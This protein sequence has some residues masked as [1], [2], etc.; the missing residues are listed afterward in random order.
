MID[1]NHQH[2]KRDA[3]SNVL[4]ARLDSV[5][6]HA[7][8]LEQL[9]R[10]LQDIAL[11]ALE[12]ASNDRPGRSVS[13]S[14]VG[15]KCARSVQLSIWPSFHPNA[16]AIKQAPLTDE[17][18]RI[19]ARGHLTEPLV[20]GW[21]KSLFALWTHNSRGYQFGFATADGQIKGYADGVFQT[22]VDDAG[23][24]PLWE[25]KTLGG[26]SFYMARRHGI[27]KAHPKYYD[28]V[29][30]LMAYLNYP[31]TLF[32]VLCGDTESAA[33][34]QLYFELVQFN[35]MHAQQVSDRAVHIL[36]A[37]RAGDLLPKASDSETKFPCSFCRFRAECW[38]GT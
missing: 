1:L 32:S 37:T 12:S 27:K 6:P 38:R 16:P 17:T 25:H 7:T 18:R 20:A 29:Q 11:A 31:A 34:G 15:D 21:L 4:V 19:F 26:K 5:I 8:R 22:P 33:Y 23:S 10:A 2:T 13:A 14:I 30:L 28:Q 3:Y 9:D 24:V 35:Q 36:R